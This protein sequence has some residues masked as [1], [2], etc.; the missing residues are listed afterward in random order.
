MSG[1]EGKE[2]KRPL[3]ICLDAVSFWGSAAKYSQVLICADTGAASG[4]TAMEMRSPKEHVSWVEPMKH[5]C[6]HL[7]G[8]SNLQAA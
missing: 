7:Q 1:V 6:S 5:I 2:H 8:R 4:R 3:A